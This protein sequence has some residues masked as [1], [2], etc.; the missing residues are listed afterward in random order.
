MLSSLKN[1]LLVVVDVWNATAIQFSTDIESVSSVMMRSTISFPYPPMSSSSV[2]FCS[3]V[4]FN[5][6]PC[7]YLQFC[8]KPKSLI[9]GIYMWPYPE[10][11]P[12]L[13]PS[14]CSGTNS[15]WEPGNIPCY[16]Y[17]SYQDEMGARL[18]IQV[19]AV[20]KTSKLIGAGNERV[21]NFFWTQKL[22]ETIL[23][24]VECDVYINTEVVVP[25]K[26]DKIIANDVLQK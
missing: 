1:R 5:G 24:V 26:P 3:N 18:R 16:V 15:D 4:F 10:T 25:C 9:H 19:N 21:T 23:L 11:C 17:W 2:Y 8:L 22:Q 6:S 13:H 14:M 7:I 20:N 12:K